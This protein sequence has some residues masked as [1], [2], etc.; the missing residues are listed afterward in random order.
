MLIFEVASC[1]MQFCRAPGNINH[2]PGGC[3]VQRQQMCSL[4]AGFVAA[5]TESSPLHVPGPGWSLLWQKMSHCVCFLSWSRLLE[6]GHW[7]NTAAA[8]GLPQQ[9]PVI[10]YETATFNSFWKRMVWLGWFP[11]VTFSRVTA[12]TC[13][14]LI[15]SSVRTFCSQLFQYMDINMYVIW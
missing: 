7:V 5:D 14:D 15:S 2:G 10:N 12:S 11:L 3:D 13:R 6:S 4:A 1:W 8:T 9:Q